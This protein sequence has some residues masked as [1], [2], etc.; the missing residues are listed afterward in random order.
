MH[1]DTNAW[2]LPA[3]AST[4]ARCLLGNAYRSGSG[5]PRNERQV[6]ELYL[7]ARQRQRSHFKG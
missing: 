3:S 5:V 2:L 4:P 6:L 7:R 1:D